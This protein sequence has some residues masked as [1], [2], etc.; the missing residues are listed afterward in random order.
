VDYLVA[1][2]ILVEGEDYQEEVDYL[3]EVEV[4]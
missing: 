4:V 2:L 3:V 1:V